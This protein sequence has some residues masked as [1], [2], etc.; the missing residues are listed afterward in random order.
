MVVGSEGTGLVV[1]DVVGIAG[2]GLSSLGLVVLAAGGMEMGVEGTAGAVEGKA[3][4]DAGIEAGTAGTVTGA[5][6][7]CPELL[8]LAVDATT[9]CAAPPF[10]RGAS[11]AA[12]AGAVGWKDAVSVEPT[13]FFLLAGNRATAISSAMPPTRMAVETRCCIRFRRVTPLSIIR[14]SSL[15]SRLGSRASTRDRTPVTV[16]VPLTRSAPETGFCGDRSSSSRP[17]CRSKVVIR[18]VLSTGV[19]VKEGEGTI[20]AGPPHA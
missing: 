18:Q 16:T 8:L 14:S 3:D 13:V 1:A 10:H 17:S 15:T 5:A 19:S 9:A 6:A 11:G 2:I 7:A 4:E 20:G 12:G